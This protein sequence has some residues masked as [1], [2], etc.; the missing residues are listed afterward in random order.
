MFHL[1]IHSWFFSP[2]VQHAFEFATDKKLRT[3]LLSSCPQAALLPCPLA[4]L[5]GY[6]SM[7]C[8]AHLLPPNYVFGFELLDFSKSPTQVTQRP[9]SA[10]CRLLGSLCA[11]VSATR[12]ALSRESLSRK[13]WSW[14]W[15]GLGRESSW[16]AGQC[17][18]SRR[19]R[20]TVLLV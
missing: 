18:R 6:H 15:P 19:N 14:S 17:L 3:P 12:D 11:Q 20:S 1:H 10:L 16:P 7:K 8:C 2:V 13:G 5:F 4:C 9:D